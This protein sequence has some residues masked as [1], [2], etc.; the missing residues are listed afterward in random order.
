MNWLKFFSVILCLGLI[1]P[2]LSAFAMEI[3]GEAP[4]S[5]SVGV[6]KRNVRGDF[7]EIT[8]SNFIKSSVGS[9]A[10][11]DAVTVEDN[12]GD[13]NKPAKV[14]MTLVGDQ[15]KHVVIYQ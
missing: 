3:N 14:V 9:Y 12:R 2:A 6:E 11:G 4:A 1:F 7:I 5:N 15:L 13:R 8:S 10:L